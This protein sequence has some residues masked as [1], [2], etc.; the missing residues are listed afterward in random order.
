MAR[1][2]DAGA[3]VQAAGGANFKK[4]KVGGHSAMLDGIIHLGSYQ[5][6]F[7]KGGIEEVKKPCNFALAIFTLLGKDDI[8]EDGSRIRAFTVFPLKNGAKANMTKL[9]DA[10]DPEEKATGFDDCMGNICSVKMVGSEKKGDDGLPEYVNYGGVSAENDEMIEMMQARVESE[11]LTPIGHIKFDEITEE[12]MKQIPAHYIRQYLL[13]EMKGTNLSFKG[14]KAEEVLLAI[15]EED[16]EFA[17]KKAKSDDKKSGTE[18][19][20]E[21]EAPAEETD[22]PDDVDSGMGADA[23]EVEY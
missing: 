19:G 20:G 9:L 17:T 5:D 4:A 15:R 21:R 23:D 6:V 18:Q 11:G 2:F 13:S 14:S 3:D 7:V 22:L 1:N 10:V 8:N 12:V 16:P